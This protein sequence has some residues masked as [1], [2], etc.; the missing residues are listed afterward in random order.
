MKTL[1]IL[2]V[3]VLATGSARAGEEFVRMPND[4]TPFDLF[5]ALMDLSADN[6]QLQAYMSYGVELLQAQSQRASAAL[7]RNR[8]VYVHDEE[9]LANELDQI[10]FERQRAYIALA[11]GATDLLSIDEAAKVQRLWARL[12]YMRAPDDREYPNPVRSGL[13]DP[14]H[15]LRET[16]DSLAPRFMYP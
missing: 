2:L 3:A 10:E 4:V 12:K 15:S 1:T 5:G 6:D 9:A 11:V 7:C 13:L 14:T 8:S 16:C